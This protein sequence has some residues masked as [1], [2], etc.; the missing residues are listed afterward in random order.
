MRTLLFFDDWL[1]QEQR[2]LD[3][4]WFKAEPWPGT[5]P[6]YDPLLVASFLSP[7]V[8]LDEKTGKWRMWATGSPDM[9]KGDEGLVVYLYSSDDGIN[10]TPEKQDRPVDRLAGENTPHAVFSGKHSSHGSLVFKDEREADPQRR[11]KAVYSEIGGAI[12]A[13]AGVSKI[14]MSPD[15][16]HW[17]I[18]NDAQWQEHVADT[19]NSILFNPYTE[20]YQFTSRVVWG[21]RRIALYQTK[22]WKKFAR[23][24]VILHPD[25]ED[26]PCVEFYGMPHFNYEG[27]F[28]GFLWKMHAALDDYDLSL[29]MKGRVDSELVYSINGTHWN[30]TNRQS[31]LPDE[32]LGVRDFLQEYPACMVMDRDGWLRIYSTAYLGGH[33]DAMQKGVQSAFMT[34]SRLRRDGFCALETHSDDG[35][36]VTRP[37]ISGSGQISLNAIVGKCG[38]IRAELRKVPDNTPIPGYELENSVPVTSDGHF[39]PLRWKERESIDRFKGEPFRLYLEMKEARLYAMRVNAEHLIASF[40]QT[41]LA[42]DYKVAHGLPLPWFVH[43]REDAYPG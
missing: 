16:I 38:F 37:L 43:N 7:S 14:A 2:G 20:C 25:P 36:I 6:S 3:R 1:I 34:I 29:R 12:L 15:G 24:Q 19:F 5:E 30:R 18:D 23:P 9:S 11:Y 31:F 26:P 39:L 32:G 13:D 42:G 8:H 40:P 33:G 21:D 17:T 35:F 41:N 4:K 10:W 22:D 28:I 27:Y